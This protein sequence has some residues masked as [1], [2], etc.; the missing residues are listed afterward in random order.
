MQKL[1]VNH[2]IDYFRSVSGS[3]VV[4]IA[5][6]CAAV[7]LPGVAAAQPPAGA[8]TLHTGVVMQGQFSSSTRP[9]EFSW[10]GNGFVE[11]LRFPASQ[12]AAVKF[13]SARPRIVPEGEFRF[14]LVSG[15]QF[16]GSLA[17][18]SD[19]T[20]VINSPRLGQV[21]VATES[22][23]QMYRV[24]GNSDLTYA[25]LAGL[26]GWESDGWR[27]DGVALWAE[28]NG[29]TLNGDLKVP[30]RALIELEIAWA[31]KPSFMMAIASDPSAEDSG[32]DGWR[33]EVWGNVLALVRE[34]EGKA[35]VCEIQKLTSGMN[36][37]ALLAYLD[38]AAG[39]MQVFTPTGE[40]LAR[41]TL[42]DVKPYEVPPVSVLTDSEVDVD[43]LKRA[44]SQAFEK[45][46][47]RLG[48]ST[49]IRLVNLGG[50]TRIERLRISKWNGQLADATD[51]SKIS[52]EMAG[53]GFQ[54]CDIRGYDPKRKGFLLDPLSETA[55]PEEPAGESPDGE[56][57][58]DQQ[59]D[60]E[61]N[62]EAEVPF[63]ALADLLSMKRL[64]LNVSSAGKLAVGLQDGTRVC[65]DVRSIGVDS[66]IVRSPSIT[67]DMTIQLA[68]IR[69]I[70][71]TGS[72]ADA[73]PE[74]PGS[75]DVFDRLGRLVVAGDEVPGRLVSAVAGEDAGCLK[76]WPDG[77]LSASL[78]DPDI[79]GRIIYRQSPAKPKPSQVTPAVRMNRGFNFGNLFLRRSRTKTTPRAAGRTTVDAHKVYLCTGDVIPCVVMSIEA[80]GISLVSEVV[81]SQRI[82][83]DQIQAIELVGSVAVPSLDDAKKQRLLT[84]PRLQQ[85]DPPTHLLCSTQGDFLRC[86]L[87]AADAEMLTVEVQLD[88][89]VVPRGRV[90]QVIWL[91]PELMPPADPAE[92]NDAE[93]SPL[94]AGDATDDTPADDIEL[95]QT[96]A[97]S[98]F[99]GQI[100]AVKTNGDR[101]TFVGSEVALGTIVGN[102][103]VVGECQF[104]LSEVDELILGE[105]I[106]VD[107][108]KYVYGGWKMQHAVRPLIAQANEDGG[109]AV[110]GTLSPLVG[111]T[112]PELKLKLLDGSEFVL[113][114]QQGKIVVL[115]F[116]ASW[117]APC[118]QTMPIVERE[119]SRFD[120]SQVQLVSVNLQERPEEVRGALERL[121]FELTVAMDIDGVAAGRF[122]ANAIPQ[123][124]VIDAA[125]V[126]SKVYVGGG[127]ETV[128][129]LAKSIDELL[130]AE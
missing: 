50:H 65:G 29:A 72:S 48:K 13:P 25:G 60:D 129:Q 46:R 105:T 74:L 115:D 78:L 34:R 111:K 123:M 56:A 26:D 23:R 18:W 95:E 31:G 38:Q 3:A 125:G 91:H 130:A 39:E 117:C 47:K 128:D 61:S 40:R 86:R 66:M 68:M 92:A 70:V 94:D 22:I 51:K 108:E 79:S 37:I 32:T 127:A 69:T 99:A 88:E 55:E 100:Q 2:M 53:G 63:V 119:L 58:A 112:S 109:M 121:G 102:G 43:S 98:Q 45:A 59:S 36:R 42:P 80:D 24:V 77:G 122:Q 113:S 21:S 49:G 16:F 124:V 9:G 75:E 44:R 62:D 107:A 35:D 52:I 84:L 5:I 4:Y 8:L 114:Q 81:S 85:N 7:C 89:I 1:F 120:S 19:G 110:D 71:G 33:F 27:E 90:A 93:G 118:M 28:Q 11:P 106:A 20:A 101:V 87:L 12:L 10:Q 41:V 6:A 83:H 103:Q 67:T 96:P 54:L 64:N 57:D 30:P 73:V 17:D 104:K 14:E 97:D 15:D 82:P 76:W 126:V 116:W